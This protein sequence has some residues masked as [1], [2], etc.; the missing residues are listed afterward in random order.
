[1]GKRSSN[2]RNPT[3][4]RLYGGTLNSHVP[5]VAIHSAEIIC[6]LHSAYLK[7]SRLAFKQVRSKQFFAKKNSYVQICAQHIISVRH[8]A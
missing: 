6:S 4:G 2:H 7:D 3:D 1:M 8:S 5:I